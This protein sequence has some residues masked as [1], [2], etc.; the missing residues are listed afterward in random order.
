MSL[1]AV[2]LFV[3][4]TLDQ[5]NEP[6]FAELQIPPLNAFVAPMPWYD[7]A[8]APQV[9]IWGSLGRGSRVTFPRANSPLQADINKAGTKQRRYTVDCWLSFTDNPDNP[10][11]DAMF[12]VLIGSVLRQL[13]T[14]NVIDPITGQA[15]Q[16]T[17][18]YTGEVSQITE[19][20][21]EFDY[22]YATVRGL[23]DQ[24]YWRYVCLIRP[25]VEEWYQS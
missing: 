7:E 11:A 3:K 25:V 4:K 21:E 24:R 10:Q 20:C 14:V 22:D 23:E 9:N 1:N 15:V 5:L 18:Q 16:V 12:P 13:E 6:W 8:Q 2:Q 17:D 19:F